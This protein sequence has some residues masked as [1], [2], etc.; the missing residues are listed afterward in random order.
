MAKE[1]ERV[2]GTV[3]LK[4]HELINAMD[5]K[6]KQSMAELEVAK[7]LRFTLTVG[8]AGKQ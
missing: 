4:W 1:I 2:E 7:V 8:S 3:E 5:G 6:A